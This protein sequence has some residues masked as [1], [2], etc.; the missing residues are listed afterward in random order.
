MSESFSRKKQAL[1]VEH[2]TY[3]RLHRLM[4]M[5]N[6][7]EQRALLAKLR[8]GVG[9]QPGTIPELWSILLDGLPDNMQSKYGEPTREEWAIYI[10]LTMYALHQQGRSIKQEPMHQPKISLGDAAKKLLDG[11]EDGR[12]RVARRFN[13]T[14][15]ATDMREMDHYLRAFVQLLRANHIAL[16]YVKLS[17]ELYLYQYEDLVGNIRLQWGQDF[18]AMNHAIDNDE[19]DLNNA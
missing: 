11:T 13:L 1:C 16:D 9:Q 14:V 19:E 17:K 10:S 5:T 7:A 15:M 2:E 6:E 4:S 18:Y 12:K 3:K 8:H